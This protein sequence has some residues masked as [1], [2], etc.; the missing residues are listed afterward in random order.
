[1]Y[2][3]ETAHVREAM[4]TPDQ[5]LVEAIEQSGREAEEGG[6]LL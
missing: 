6:G 2:E 4:K 5:S 3:A 1:M